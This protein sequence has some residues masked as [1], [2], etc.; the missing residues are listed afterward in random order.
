MNI[1]SFEHV[2]K[3]ISDPSAMLDRRQTTE[4]G[5]GQILDERRTTVNRWKGVVNDVPKPNALYKGHAE[6][7]PAI[8]AY[9]RRKLSL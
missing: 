4:D 7:Q 5:H 3:E 1:I 6:T 9:D 8:I 2:G